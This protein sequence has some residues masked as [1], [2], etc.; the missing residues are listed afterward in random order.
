VLLDHQYKV[1]VVVA[2]L[3]DKFHLHL[4]IQHHY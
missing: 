3:V 2:D 4:E 1:L